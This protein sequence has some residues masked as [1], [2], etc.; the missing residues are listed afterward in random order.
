MSRAVTL[1]PGAHEISS[2]DIERL[3]VLAK[4]A[5]DV[6][7][8]GAPLSVSVPSGMSVDAV[9]EFLRCRDPEDFVLHS[10]KDVADVQRTTLDYLGVDVSGMRTAKELRRELAVLGDLRRGAALLAVASNGVYNAS[11]DVER[12]WAL[13]VDELKASPET[14]EAEVRDFLML[15]MGGL[16][17]GLI[18]P[19]V[20]AVLRATTKEFPC[21]IA[22]D[23]IS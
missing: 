15:Y 22:A 14:L 12:A 3:P 11:R 19:E 2:D 6:S 5:E 7:R 9:V 10:D 13:R 1:E 16:Q 8:F 18:R 23:R 21:G 20:E 17:E 4:L